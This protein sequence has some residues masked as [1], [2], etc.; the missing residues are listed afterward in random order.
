MSLRLAKLF[1]VLICVAGFL[2]PAE[3]QCKKPKDEDKPHG[4]N[5]PVVVAG[6]TVGRIYGR[7]LFPDDKAEE[8]WVRAKDVVV[9]IYNYSGDGSREGMRK[10]L[11]EQ[12]RVAACLTGGDGKFSFPELE[13][14][15]YLFRAGT[16]APSRYDEIQVILLIDPKLGK[17]P[18]LTI[19]MP[20]GT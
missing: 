13:P 19:L 7:T 18:E 12:K 20:A 3:A 1:G 8:G 10:V 6:R 9:E 14:G 11:R 4:A 16:R 2:Q 15:M 17:T 5:A